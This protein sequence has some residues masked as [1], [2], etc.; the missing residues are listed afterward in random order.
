MVPMASFELEFN[1]VLVQRIKPAQKTASGIYIPE[2]NQEKLNIANVIAVGPG[3]QNAQG[4]LVKL[5]VNAGDKVIIPA[6][7]GSNVKVG[8]E[9][10]LILRD[11]DLLAKVEE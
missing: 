11:S 9:E 4:D 8:E 2:K 5:S 7:G 1:T 3:I 10:Y 6:F